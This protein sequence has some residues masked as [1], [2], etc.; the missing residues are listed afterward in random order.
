MDEGA[1]REREFWLTR[2]GAL[3]F[4]NADDGMTSVF[5]HGKDLAAASIEGL[6]EGHSAKPWAFFLGLPRAEDEDAPERPTTFAASSAA[7]RAVWI[8]QL[9]A[10]RG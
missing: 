3:L 6:P 1:W 9:T 7:A 8:E 10:A 4:H 5:C 2:S